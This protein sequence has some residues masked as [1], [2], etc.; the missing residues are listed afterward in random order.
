MTLMSKS[1]SIFFA[2]HASKLRWTVLA[3][4]VGVAFSVDIFMERS[5][6]EQVRES[7]VNAC[8]QSL[9][10][11][12]CERRTDTHH[13]KCFE[14][15]YTSMIFTFGRQRWESFKLLDY[16]ACMN[17]DDALSDGMPASGPVVGI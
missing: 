13:V 10:L 14:L 12:L 8:D 2:T 4:L 5:I 3:L 16:E 9:S 17:R 6:R 15:A 7:W 11:A 1:R